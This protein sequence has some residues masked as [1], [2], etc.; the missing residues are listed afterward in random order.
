MKHQVKLNLSQL[1]LS[2]ALFTL[3]SILILATVFVLG[4]AVPGL[5][6]ASEISGGSGG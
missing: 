6:I 3:M 2:G 5:E 1:M 4:D